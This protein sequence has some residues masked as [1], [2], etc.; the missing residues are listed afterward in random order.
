MITKKH[1][2]M[3]FVRVLHIACFLGRY[4]SI[5]ERSLVPHIAKNN[6]VAS[7]MHLEPRREY[8]VQAKKGTKNKGHKPK[9]KGKPKTDDVE[10]DT[11]EIIDDEI[12][13]TIEDDEVVSID[14]S[15]P[16][17]GAM[18]NMQGQPSAKILQNGG[19]SADDELQ[20]DLNTQQPTIGQQDMCNDQATG[21]MPHTRAHKK[22]MA[23]NANENVETSNCAKPRPFG[24]NIAE[25]M[26]AGDDACSQKA[27]AIE[28]QTEDDTAQEDAGI[29]ADTTG[30]KTAKNDADE[31]ANGYDWSP[32]V[33]KI[34]RPGKPRVVCIVKVVPIP[35]TK[36]GKPW[37]DY[38]NN[39]EKDK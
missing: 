4:S 18:G 38:K 34:V 21:N 14:D 23:N 27:N 6:L 30:Q 20:Q 10:D 11:V 13:E 7:K 8:A 39:S 3:I 28:S 2:V 22:D 36:D 29:Q 17:Q 9:H 35:V 5:D 37:K 24:Q 15:M 25:G 16:G 26:A 32:K 33:R 31:D 19:C 12:D 1:T